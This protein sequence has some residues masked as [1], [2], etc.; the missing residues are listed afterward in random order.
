MSRE[1]KKI[2]IS[3]RRD[4]TAPYAGWL[5]DR[6]AQHYGASKIFM[7]VAYLQPGADF[8]RIIAQAI[9]SC[10]VLIALIGPA[11]VGSTSNGKT[12]IQEADDWVRLEIESAL[13]QGITVIPL[14]VDGALLPSPEKLP[15]DLVRIRAKNCFNLSY[16]TFSEDV[17]KLISAIDFPVVGVF[18]GD[19]A[20]RIERGREARFTEIDRLY[21]ALFDDFSDLRYRHDPFI[22][23]SARRKQLDALTDTVDPDEDIAHLVLGSFAHEYDTFM[24][25]VRSTETHRGLCALTQRRLVYIP[26]RKGLPAYFLPYSHILNVDRGLLSITFTLAAGNTRLQE[27][28]PRSK[29]SSV[30]DYI[31]DRVARR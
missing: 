19:H 27:I 31:R 21:R 29:A 3:Y 17:R 7:D 11:W 13:D 14:L 4:D 10:D 1:E 20:K 28:K 2:F 12:R 23:P 6:L 16:G 8:P 25:V 24:E 15:P 26:W 22:Q 18:E 9:S 5:Q 30:Y